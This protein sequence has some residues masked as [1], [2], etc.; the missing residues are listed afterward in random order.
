MPLPTA[1][2]SALAVRP[3]GWATASRGVAAR[4]RLASLP[5]VEAV[6]LVMYT[7]LGL[8]ATA[9]LTRL[10]SADKVS[11]PIRAWVVNRWGSGSWL[12]YLLHCRWCVSM[13]VAPL[14]AAAVIWLVPAYRQ[15]WWLPTVLVGALLALTFSHGTALLAGLEDDD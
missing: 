7:L 12:G 14:A 3:G 15:S 2:G 8:F 1:S 11:K 9:R 10:I 13:Y 5:G 4:E 6:L